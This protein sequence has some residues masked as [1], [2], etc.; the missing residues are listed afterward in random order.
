[1]VS[2]TVLMFDFGSKLRSVFVVFKGIVKDLRRGAERRIDG[3]GSQAHYGD[4][5]SYDRDRSRFHSLRWQ[6]QF[7]PPA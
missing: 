3:E 4:G 7:I 1:M 2:L 6:L 5:Q